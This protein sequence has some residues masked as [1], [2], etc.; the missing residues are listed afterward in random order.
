MPPAVWIGCRGDPGTA[1]PLSG[2]E[3]VL[4]GRPVDLN[5]AVAADLAAVPGLGAA[6]AA[7]VVADREARG[8]FPSVEALRRV[9]GIGPAKLARARP[10]LEVRGAER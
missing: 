4:L 5:A 2:P 10:C 8:P 3:L 6:L 1:R 7:E 9:R